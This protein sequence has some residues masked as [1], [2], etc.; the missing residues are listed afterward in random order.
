MSREALDLVVRGGTVVTMDPAR[1]VVRADVRLRGRDIVAVG[2]RA[3]EGDGRA[4]R[5]IDARGCAVLPGL[6]QAHVHLCQALFRGMADDLPLLAWLRE[7]IWPLEAAHDEKSLAASA[8]LGL[9]EMLLSGTTTILDMGT[10]HAHDVVFEA[11]R[12]SGIRGASGKTMMDA[13]DGVPKKLRETTKASLAESERL[14]DAWHGRDEGRLRYAFAPRFVLSCTGKLM[15]GAAELARAKG[16][17]VHTHVAEHAEERA[18]VK[19]ALGRD[20]VDELARHGISGPR[21]VLAHG[22]QLRTSEMRRLANAGTRIV[23]C[24]SANL[25]LASGIARVVEMRRA[26]IVVGLGADGAPCN[27]RMDPWTEL[28]EAALLAK[29]RDHDAASLAA[30]SALELAT[31]DGARVLGLDDEIG[32]IEVGKRADV[33]VVRIDRLHTEPGGDVLGR[34]VYAC[35]PSD[36]QHVIIDG[37]VVVQDGTLCTLDAER[38]RDEARRQAKRVADRAGI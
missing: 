22:V 21:A 32:S 15:K 23:H 35:T 33:I 20:D 10:V 18:A 4:A 26:G 2:A 11:M 25:K 24:P 7:R 1:R 38:V 5:V 13:G 28:R 19:K 3:A 29:V 37:R 6:V 34:L 12:E 30:S 27:N 36:V 9:A 14:C 31:I 17:L 8:R 16:A